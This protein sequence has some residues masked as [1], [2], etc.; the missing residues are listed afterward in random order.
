MVSLP[1]SSIPRPGGPDAVPRPR[2]V[3]AAALCAVIVSACGDGPSTSNRREE[4]GGSLATVVFSYRA[5]TVTD[6]AVVAAHRACGD[7]VGPTHIHL[8]WISFFRNNL[9]AVGPQEW[10]YTADN[11]PSG[12]E[13]QIRV[14]DPNACTG[15]PNGAVTVN[16]YANGV[17]LT[18]G[19]ATPGNGLEPGLAFRVAPD[20]TVTP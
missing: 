16:V 15:D 19:V 12:G 7:H 17:L 11:V 8:G 3:S 13:Q 2:F 5:S 1:R 6:P 14:N 4:E 18:K 9:A 10:R 20:G